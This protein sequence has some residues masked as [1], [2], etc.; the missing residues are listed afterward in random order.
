MTRFP[1]G[2]HPLGNE[3][4]K[5]V[6][7]IAAQNDY[8][9]FLVGGYIRDALLHR[10]TDS[11]KDLDYA[12]EVDGPQVNPAMS[13]AAIVAK[14]VDGHYVP[15]DDSNDTAR[16]VLKTG[17]VL[18]FAGC[19]GGRIATDVW[20]RDFSINAL[21]WNPSQADEIFDCVDGV[22]DLAALKIR[23]LSERSLID[24]PLRL[25]RAF[26]FA[27]TISGTIEEQTM[28]W[29]T[30]HA[31]SLPSVAVERIN[32]ELF[33]LLACERTAAAVE[34]M[35]ACGLLEAIFPELEPTRAVT[36]NAFHHLGLFEHSVET[37]PQLELKLDCVADW[38][39][40]S[41]AGEVSPGVTRLA[42]TKVAC[43][44]HDIG[45]PDTWAITEEGRHTFYGHDK[46]G[47]DMCLTISDRMKW[48]RP[49][50]RLIVNLVK[51]HLRPGALFH[52]G[53]PTEKAINKLYRSVQDDMPQLMLL[54]FADFGATRGPGLMG[55]MR[56][57]LEK[58]FFDLLNGYHQY[59]EESRHREKLMNGNDVMH[60]LSL[61]PG[62]MVGE[63]L[64][65]LDEAQECKEVGNRAEAESFIKHHY[66]QKYCK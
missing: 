6:I 20:R 40:E 50:E 33:A 1:E 24:D 44:L 57:R 46:L 54:A 5:R 53:P 26:R 34:E 55:E 21:V 56:D 39:L 51:W 9:V 10:K 13:L 29:I 32:Y 16:V 63:L 41:S 19:V 35:A 4:N 43:L 14:S 3:L 42:A 58:N 66:E 59:K 7:A 48:S 38:V 17:E 47:A 37:I 28:A 30:K 49:V 45:K 25:L 12:V 27:V 15:L 31:M 11:F 65:A 52:Q 36:A 64:S 23:A 2:T 8:R 60:L 22:R 18:D 61:P 62:P